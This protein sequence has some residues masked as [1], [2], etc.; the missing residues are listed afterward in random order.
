MRILVVDDDPL[1]LHMVVYR[2]RQWGHDVIS[3]TDGDA[4]WKVLE[5]GSVPNVAIVDWIMPGINGPELCQKIRGRTDCPYVYIVM[6]TGRNNPEDL[7]AGLDAG[8]DD[9]LTKPFH[10]GELDA[11]LRAGKRIVDLQ[12]E[13]I[14]TRETLRIQAMQDPLTQILNHGAIVDTLLREIDRAHREQQPLSLI[15]ADLDG[16]KNVNDSYGHVSGDQVL[17]EVARRMRFCLRSYDAIGRYGGEE[18][19]MVLPN[20]DAAQAV[21]L[22]ERIRVA[23]SQKP[24]RVHNADLTVTVSQGVTT[25]TDP[26][27]IPIEQLIQ[28]ADGVLY[29]VKNSG[30]NGVEFA[31]FH[32]HTDETFSRVTIS[33]ISLKQ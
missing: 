12:N 15:L 23:V 4:A 16:F 11:R 9:Y 17:V 28:S 6:L 18:F 26:C 31:Q 25:W 8:A 14:S 21:R 10:L 24:F 32:K 19:L 7:I 13:L 5:R 27:P 33:P 3:C 29:L 2:L 20:S 1:T 30:R 22:A